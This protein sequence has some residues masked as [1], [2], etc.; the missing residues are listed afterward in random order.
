MPKR[1]PE[2]DTVHS[3]DVEKDSVSPTLIRATPA[4]VARALFADVEPPDPSRRKARKRA[5]RVERLG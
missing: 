4:E 5:R 3:P 2:P 1:K